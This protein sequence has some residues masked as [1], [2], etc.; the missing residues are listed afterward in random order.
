VKSA[1]RWVVPLTRAET[2]ARSVGAVVF[3]I[4]Q[5]AA[6]IAEVNGVLT[7]F[8]VRLGDSQISPQVEAASA[9]MLSFSQYRNW[10]LSVSVN[11]PA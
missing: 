7:G 10:T 9:P 11:A 6:F 1:R 2:R 4:A 3:T 5:R 8:A